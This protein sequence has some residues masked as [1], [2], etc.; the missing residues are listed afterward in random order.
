M[1]T[2]YQYLVFIEKENRTGKTA[3]FECRN[4]K[5]QT[6]LGLIKWYG[7]WRQY[8]YFPVVQAVYSDGC[9]DDISNFINQLKGE[10]L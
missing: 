8:C 7:A 10:K 9:L 5:S 4:K 3:I 6:V 1:Q 2:E